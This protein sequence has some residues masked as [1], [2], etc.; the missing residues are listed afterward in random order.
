LISPAQ[1]TADADADP[2]FIISSGRQQATVDVCPCVVDDVDDSVSFAVTDEDARC[3]ERTSAKRPLPDR[4]SNRYRLSHIDPRDVRPLDRRAVDRW[5]I[6]VIN[7]PSIVAS[8]VNS[9][10]PTAAQFIALTV[11]LYRGLG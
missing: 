8:F 9:V 5:T 10:R 3:S 11:H 4:L 2:Y 1:V 7:R 6:S